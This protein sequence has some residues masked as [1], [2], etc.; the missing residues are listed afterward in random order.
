MGIKK[1]TEES[2]GGEGLIPFPTSGD[3]FG[4]FFR[5]KSSFC[6][7]TGLTHIERCSCFVFP[8]QATA[9]R[10]SWMLW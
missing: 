4:R 5:T 6:K 7:E 9:V 8:D 2:G 3:E 10:V 1:P